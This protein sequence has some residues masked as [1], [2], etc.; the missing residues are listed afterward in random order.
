MARRGE[1][2]EQESKWAA[3]AVVQKFAIACTAHA[4]V[5]HTSLQERTRAW[6]LGKRGKTRKQLGS[7]QDNGICA[8][9]TLKGGGGVHRSPRTAASAAAS[10]INSKLL[11]AEMLSE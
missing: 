3:T 7:M 2:T 4:C 6:R 5:A 9:L 8:V 10:S 11:R 1:C